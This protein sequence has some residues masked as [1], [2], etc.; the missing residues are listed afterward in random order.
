MK[1]ALKASDFKDLSSPP[2]VGDLVLIDM[3]CGMKK[4][5]RV[6]KVL[7]SGRIRIGWRDTDYTELFTPSTGTGELC[8]RRTVALGG[9]TICHHIRH[10][11][12][13]GSK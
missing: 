5:G 1:T 6:V 4:V 9:R 11:L 12:P 13:R 10:Y 2:A 7:E 8:Y 3:I